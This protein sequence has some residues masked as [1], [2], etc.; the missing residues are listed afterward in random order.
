[1]LSITPQRL[2]VV[3][4]AVSYAALVSCGS[5]PSTFDVQR[6]FAA[7]HPHYVVTSVTSRAV[8][9]IEHGSASDGSYIHGNT[10]FT[11]TYRKPGDSRTYTYE[12]SFHR[13]AEGWVEDSPKSR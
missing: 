13:V 10:V 1:M 2:A 5:L 9:A 12:R 6:K 3:L 8:D 7:E 4:A 11:I